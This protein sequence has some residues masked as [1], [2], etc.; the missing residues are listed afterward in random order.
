MIIRGARSYLKF[1]QYKPEELKEKREELHISRPEIANLLGISDQSVYNIE[2]GTSGSEASV[3]LY[4][5]ILD[6]YD[7]YL[8]GYVPCFM[9]ENRIE[10]IHEK[11][12]LEKRRAKVWETAN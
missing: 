7:A 3:I 1:H 5:M 4:S 11:E 9:H 2:R 10:R 12:F 6:R 8:D